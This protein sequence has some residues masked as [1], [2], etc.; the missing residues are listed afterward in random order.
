MEPAME[1]PPLLV[2]FTINLG[3]P[4]LSGFHAREFELLVKKTNNGDRRRENSSNWHLLLT[5][6]LKN[7]Y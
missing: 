4:F 7:I 5:V 3:I 6:S 1:L 2:F